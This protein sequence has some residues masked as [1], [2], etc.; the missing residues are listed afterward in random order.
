MEQSLPLTPAV[1]TG[2][3]RA[4]LLSRLEAA[5]AARPWLPFLILTVACALVWGQSLSFH[6]VW[7]DQYFI[8]DNQALRSPAR[9][10]DLF[11]KES[12]QVNEIG[13]QKWPLWRPI[14]T[15]HYAVLVWACGRP[16]P[17]VFH[18]ANLVWHL[19]AAA[20]LFALTLRLLTFGAADRVPHPRLWAGLA[21]LGFCVHPA[22]SEVVCW[23]K[24]LDDSMAAALLFGAL[25]AAWN[26]WQPEA[27]RRGHW[28]A[29]SILLFALGLLSKESVVTLF[30]LFI[31]PLILWRVRTPAFWAWAAAQAFTA[32]VFVLLRHQVLQVTAQVER[33]IS[34]TYGQTLVDMLPV[35]LLYLR[36]FAGAPPFL[37]DYSFMAGGTSLTALPNLAGLFTLAAAAGVFVWSLLRSRRFPAL[38][39]GLALLGLALVPVSNLIP[40]MQYFAIRF[41]YLPLAGFLVVAAAV[42]SRPGASR[43]CIP[44]AAVLVLLWGGVAV[45]ESAKWRNE[46]ALLTH[47]YLNSPPSVRIV[48]NYA[49]TLN[50]E[51][52]DAELREVLEKHEQ[53]LRKSPKM[54]WVRAMLLAR[55]GRVA[56]AEPKLLA[57]RKE[58]DADRDY[59]MHLGMFYARQRRHRDAEPYF[60]EVTQRWPLRSAGWRNLGIC[61]NDQGR[62][63]E[64]QPALEHAVRLWPRDV[65]AWKGLSFAAWKQ[66]DWVLAR[67]ALARL[68][69]L[70]PGNPDHAAL[71]AQ[72]P[73]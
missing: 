18:A 54:G 68:A 53:L 4:D 41:A 29:G 32:V 61:L 2:G 3:A 42:L 63:E 44:G 64:A 10:L 26:A 6:F 9:V 20:L 14:R 24:S 23:A 52:R 31:F 13:D 25:L 65:D 16:V 50:A 62:F 30:P 47:S 11:T 45:G 28:A 8:T 67:Q 33:P 5:L 1:E 48:S 36:A 34:G 27:T 55:E 12:A 60:R 58:L 19:L 22:V 49:V 43:W 71:L 57:L 73:G 69:E 46:P 70:E 38:P 39:L 35:V 66:Q 37:T 15:L 59:V 21:A 17:G 72:V 51:E 56:E 7:D 40:M